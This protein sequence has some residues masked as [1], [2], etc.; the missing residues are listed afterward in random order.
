MYSRNIYTGDGSTTQYAVNF[1][2]GFLSRSHVICHVED[3]V[4]GLLLPIP[5]V[6][7]WLS[8]GLVDI[9]SAP[10]SGK[11]VLLFRAT[12]KDFLVHDYA[13][14]A[15]IIAANLDDSNLQNIFLAQE[16]LDYWLESDAYRVRTEFDVAAE[17][18]QAEKLSTVAYFNASEAAVDI[19]KAS[20]V[21]LFDAAEVLVQSE[22]LST[23]KFFDGSEAEI[24]ALFAG[25]TGR[26]ISSIAALRLIDGAIKNIDVTG[27]YAAGDGGAGSFYWDA[28][29]VEA[30][31]AGTIIKVTAV[32]TG[33][34]KRAVSDSLSIKW[35]GATGNGLTDDT[36]SIQAT[37]SVA[38][39]KTI[40]FP[41]GDYLVSSTISLDNLNFS[42]LRFDA[43]TILA[44]ANNLTVFKSV[45]NAWGVKL[46]DPQIFGN[47]FTGVVAFDV[48]RLEGLGAGIFRSVLR[49][50]DTGI[51][52]RSLCVGCIIDDPDMVNVDKPIISLDSAGGVCIRHPRITTYGSIGIDIRAAVVYG[53]IG[54]QILGGYVQDGI[55][56]IQDAGADTQVQGTYF[57]RNTVA[58]VSL[59]AGSVFFSSNATNHPAGV[60]ATAYKGRGAD[61]ANISF[62]FMSSGGRLGLFDFDATNTN[63]VR[64]VLLGKSG[65]NQPIGVITGI[66]KYMTTQSSGSFTPTVAGATVAGTAT[67][68]S[69][70]GTWQRIGDRVF[71]DA[72]VTW[73]GHTGSGVIQLVGIPSENPI[74]APFFGQVVAPGFAYTGPVLYMYPPAIG[75]A[76][77]LYN[78]VQFSTSGALSFVPFAASGSLTAHIEYRT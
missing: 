15:G 70:I 54:L 17:L 42:D 62:P 56:G 59:V 18:V 8:D 45:T 69:Q 71:I 40:V 34:W 73:S 37:C 30:D 28:A 60:G 38:N 11:R 47:S 57:E 29:S 4:D 39:G 46:F 65:Q 10:A 32:V 25:A 27:Y 7:T 23:I 12:P 51:F 6:L 19:E 72:A 13:D 66:S 36:L 78:I 50:L 31:N 16:S 5:R 52:L 3:E 1:T 35:F 41:R 22:K 53:N 67:Y 61:A 14:G 74:A 49:D 77:T 76:N 24:D 48:I 2:L 33:R 43:A 63:C 55:I 44:G 9:G 26:P 68:S 20:T 58:D 75:G 64:N 21:A